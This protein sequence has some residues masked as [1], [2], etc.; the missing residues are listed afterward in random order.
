MK[1]IKILKE[2]IKELTREKT[3]AQIKILRID[4]E[5]ETLQDEI[6]VLQAKMLE[7]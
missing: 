6:I 7:E 5:V 2:R 1:E 3:K 4:A